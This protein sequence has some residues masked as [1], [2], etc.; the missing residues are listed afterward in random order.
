[1]TADPPPALNSLFSRVSFSLLSIYRLP[2]SRP[3]GAALVIQHVLPT[4]VQ[5]K[6]RAVVGHVDFD[7]GISALSALRCPTSLKL[8]CGCG[9]T[10]KKLGRRR[11]R[12]VHPRLVGI[13]L[14][15]FFSLFAWL[16]PPSSWRCGHRRYLQRAAS[17]CRRLV[18]LSVVGDAGEVFTTHV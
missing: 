17:V 5:N 18:A 7:A 2:F 10:R 12:T 11:H 6:I 9:A 8:R 1:M 15:H 4:P 16:S 14:R 3:S 13:R